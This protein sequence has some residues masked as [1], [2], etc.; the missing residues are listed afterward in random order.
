[1]LHLGLT[2]PPSYCNKVWDPPIFS[3]ENFF[4]KMTQNDLKWILN[5]TFK[6]VTF[7]R[8]FGSFGINLQ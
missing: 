6:N 1:M 7:C 5:T 3:P 4:T 8:L 2:R